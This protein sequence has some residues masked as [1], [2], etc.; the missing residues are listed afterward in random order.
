MYACLYYSN[1]GKIDYVTGISAIGSSWLVV[2]F[3]AYRT[4]L[5][6]ELSSFW[7]GDKYEL[8]LVFKIMLMKKILFFL[9][10]IPALAM[11]QNVGIGNPTPAEKLD[12]TGNVNITG[13]L[14]ANGNAGTAGQ[15][16]MS[17]G[18]G[19]SWGS[20]A[21]YKRCVMIQSGSGTWNVPAGVTEV[22]VELWGGGSGG[23][24]NCGGTGGGYARTVQTVTPGS[25]ITYSI[26]FG[27]GAG[28][29]TTSTAGSTQVNIGLGNLTA[30]G[31]GGVAS[32]QTGYPQS[33]TS[34]FAEYFVAPGNRGTI[35][36]STF[37]QRTST[38][39]VQTIRYGSGGAPVGFANSE[40]VPGDVIV[41]ENVTTISFQYSGNAIE[42]SAGGSA[43]QGLG[44]NGG[45]G[46]ILFWYN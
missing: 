15:V 12:V 7:I 33:G 6:P 41:L 20:T 19:L 46:L 16:L 10:M 39:Y 14:K 43:G 4:K 45:P 27:S 21:G 29:T 3:K 28:G 8:N 30:L 36:T 17:T 5:L 38:I 44:W 24:I 25:G 26:G 1:G 13:A 2:L 32:T 37:G 42:Y 40:S 35:T 34:T 23:T 11:A 31:G 9:A 18:T 22:M